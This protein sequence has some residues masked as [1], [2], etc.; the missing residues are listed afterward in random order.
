MTVIWPDAT[1]NL[2]I[3]LVVNQEKK[4]ELQKQVFSEGG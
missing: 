3:L 1:L 4:E 2:I